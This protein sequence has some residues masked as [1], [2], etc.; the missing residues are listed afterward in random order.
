MRRLVFAATLI[1][2]LVAA[3][4]ALLAGSDTGHAGTPNPPLREAS[5]PPLGPHAEIASDKIN[6]RF[7]S[8]ASVSQI[9]H[10][11]AIHGLRTLKVQARAGVYQ[12]AVP[13]GAD[14][15]AVLATYR[16]DPLVAEANYSYVVRATGAPNDTNYSYEW[17][18]QN[19]VGGMWAQAAWD[20]APNHGQGVVVAVIDTGVAYENFVGPGPINPSTTYKKAPDLA[21]KTF[22]APWDFANNDSHAN[23][24][25]GHG[26]HVT[27]TIAEDTNNNYG[28]V[29][30]AYKAT[31]MPIKVLAFD[32]TGNDA[33]LIAA[34]YYAVDHGARVINMSLGFTGTGTP[35]ADGV[36]CSE[37]VGLNAALDYA[38]SHNVTVVAAA[39]NESGTITCPAAYP[40]VISVGA[41]R[42]DGQITSYSNFGSRLDVAAPGGDPNVDQN[43]DGFSD[44][45]PQETYCYDSFTLLL[46]Q[47]YDAFC[48]I[49]ESGTSM[50]TPHVVGAAALLLGEDPSLTPD[51]V[52][53][54]LETTARDRGAAGWDPYYGWGEIRCVRRRV[55]AEGPRDPH[56][57]PDSGRHEHANSHLHGVCDADRARDRHAGPHAHCVRDANGDRH[58]HAYPHLD[59]VC[60]ADGPSD[61]YANSH[62]DS[63]RDANGHCHTYGR[64]D[65]DA[66]PW[67][68]AAR[69]EPR[70]HRRAAAVELE[71]SRHRDG[72]QRQ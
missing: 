23:D 18:M 64:A 50:A 63:V 7:R 51:Q 25:N 14:V 20:V 68:E 71:R 4:V 10:A 22:V 42:F 54:Y 70:W 31:I 58:R 15:A 35:D 49:F 61:E 47:S 56:R 40:T 66:H 30:V 33:D 8:G 32:G 43:H 6:V 3:P 39:G 13:A 34:I 65:L 16:H 21:T 37:V 48:D 38:Y 26:T 36:F 67:I 11:N 53:A 44:G 9:D 1:V 27:G 19:T 52:R 60:H 59:S 17:D 24:D 29:G 69:R 55:A 5:A 62:V 2:T 28:V 46:L 57:Y 45:V 72:L 12:L 41:T